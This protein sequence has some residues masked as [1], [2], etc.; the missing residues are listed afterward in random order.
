MVCYWDICV[1]VYKLFGEY[2][3]EC[4]LVLV[5]ENS[6]E[7]LLCNEFNLL[8]VDFVDEV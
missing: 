4:Y 1:L 6:G 5:K 2:S 8:M 3:W 7:K